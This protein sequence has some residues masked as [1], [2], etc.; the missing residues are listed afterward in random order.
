MNWELKKG[1][2]YF[3]NQEKINIWEYSQEY[4]RLTEKERKMADFKIK[5]R[6]E[7]W[8]D[9]IARSQP[10]VIDTVA[11]C[12]VDDIYRAANM[13]TRYNEAV[14]EYLGATAGVAMKWFTKQGIQIQYMTNNTFSDMLRPLLVFPLIYLKSG[15]AYVCPQHISWCEM[16]E[17]GIPMEHFQTFYEKYKAIGKAVA[18]DLVDR[19]CRKGV[20]FIHLDIDAG[21]DTF[22]TELS[23]RGQKGKVLIFRDEAPQDSAKIH[24]L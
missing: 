8:L 12:M 22:Q 13:M 15:I 3:D 24:Y 19:Y 14:T 23:Y 16:E 11:G 1:T 6:M 4:G 18:A 2:D 10:G 7:G 9:Q 20:P 17:N 21:I 5:I